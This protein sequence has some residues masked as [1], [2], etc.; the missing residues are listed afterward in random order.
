MGAEKA[1]AREVG[2]ETILRRQIQLLPRNRWDYIL[3]DCPPAL[4]TVTV[5]ALVAAK[6]VLV[7]VEAHIMTLL[8]LAQLLTTV[9]IVQERLNPEL[10]ITGILPCRVDGRTRHAARVVEELRREFGKKVFRTVIRENVGLAEAP[11]FC[12]PITEYKSGSHGAEDYRALA[13]ELCMQKR[14]T[15]H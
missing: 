4:G 1:L 10:A 14:K 12:R 11:A 15:S 3:M 13:R 6:E 9:E 8:G 5:N 2:A 7:P